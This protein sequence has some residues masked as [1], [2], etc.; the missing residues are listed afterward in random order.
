VL[1]TCIIFVTFVGHMLDLVCQCEEKVGA[2]FKCK[3][4]KGTKSAR[5]GDIWLKEHLGHRGKN[6]NMFRCFIVSC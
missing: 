4:C 5:R 3:Y 2:G 6:E 1:H